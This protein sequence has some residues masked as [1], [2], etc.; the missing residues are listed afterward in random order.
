MAYDKNNIFFKIL[1]KE[2]PSEIIIEGKY[3]IVIKDIKPKASVHVLVIPKGEYTD[4]GDFIERASSEE[5][6]DFNKGIQLAIEK[7][8]LKKGGYR[9]ISNCGDFGEQ[10]VPH[11]HVHVLGNG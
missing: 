7:L 5:I 3:F 2:V 11:M 6:F 10:E 9:L 1:H 8:Q 4:Y